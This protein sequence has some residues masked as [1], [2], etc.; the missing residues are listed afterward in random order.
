MN[1]AYVKG[2]VKLS[3]ILKKGDFHILSKRGVVFIK[4]KVTSEEKT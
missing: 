1:R 4:W 3:Q 2:G